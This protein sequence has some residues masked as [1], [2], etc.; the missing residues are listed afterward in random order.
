MIDIPVGKALVAVE[1]NLDNCEGCFLDG[2]C[3]G[4]L[5]CQAHDRR[6]HLDVIFKLVD[7]PGEATA[8]D[9]GKPLRWE[10]N[11]YDKN[12]YTVGYFVECPKCEAGYGYDPSLDDDNWNNFDRYKYC[13]TCGIRLLPMEDK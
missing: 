1:T 8:K 5:C 9:S 10:I 11:S 2:K 12:D 6:D 7:W 4:E 13:P 3:A